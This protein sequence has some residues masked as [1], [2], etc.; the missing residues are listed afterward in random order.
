MR[1]ARSRA[2]NGFLGCGACSRR[3]IPV[4]RR[5]APGALGRQFADRRVP[6]GRES[7][8]GG[9]RPRA[10]APGR[11]ADRRPRSAGGRGR[12][13][14]R[15]HGRDPSR[16]DRRL[17]A[18]RGRRV[19]LPRRHAADTP[20][21]S[22]ADGRGGPRRRP[23]RGPGVRRP[24]RPPGAVLGR[25]V[26]TAAPAGRRPGRSRRPGRARRAAGL[27][28]GAGRWCFVRRGYAGRVGGRRTATLWRSAAER[29]IDGADRFQGRS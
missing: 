22:G 8:A 6:G 28:S 29:G 5:Q 17:T 14:G 2:R 18:G 23:C 19:C 25:A 12:G 20:H 26:P 10:D 13:L 15:G 1:V 9:G 21:G 24:D 11:P 27:C 3:R 7:G 4:R 16:R